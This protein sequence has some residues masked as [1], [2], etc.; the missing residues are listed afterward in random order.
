MP[1]ETYCLTVAGNH[2]MLCGE[3]GSNIIC[4]NCDD[5]HNVKEAESE[6]IRTETVRW[7]R[8][9]MSN[10][11]NN[12]KTGAIVIIMQRVHEDDVSGAILANQLDYEHLM[13]PMEYDVTRQVD[14]DGEPI[15]T[16]I[17]WY[18]P[19]YDMGDTLDDVDGLLAWPE[20]FDEEVTARMKHDMGPYGF[21]GQ[22]QQA[23]APRGGGIFKRDWWQLWEG[24]DGKFPTF[25]YLIGSL[26]GAFTDK[27]QNDPS[28]LTIWGIF[29][30]DEGKRRIMLVHAWRK[31]LQFSGPRIE[32][33]IGESKA[34]WVKRTQDTWGLVEWLRHTC[35]RFHVDL[36]L[37]EAKASGISAAQ[38]LRSR[39]DDLD[40]AIQ[41]CPVKGDKLAR[42]LACQ[43]TFS[44]Q[45]VYAPDRE[46]AEMVIDEMAVFPKGKHDDLTDSTT[47]AIKYL[48]D[49]GLAQTDLEAN[50][51]EM[52]RVTHD[53]RRQKRRRS[54][55]GV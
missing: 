46:W 12:M 2:N 9:A 55:Y 22:Y 24:K 36:L 8:E 20:R 43:A 32:M 11:L 28:A 51:E 5:P 29:Q 53:G 33:E 25:E 17:G 31:H 47:Q 10:R 39:Y 14:N 26:D 7:F 3:P 18:D 4:S 21:S 40:F 54:I 52:E 48:R 34:A 13:V 42:A 23:P 50:R 30:S 41:L 37:V 45:L 38:E 15:R 49:N 35:E 44:Q 16:S 6:I 1:S 27:E 19:R